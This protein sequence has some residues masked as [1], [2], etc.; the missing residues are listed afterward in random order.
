MP[1]GSCILGVVGDLPCDVVRDRAARLILDAA[2]RAFATLPNA[3]SGLQAGLPQLVRAPAGEPSYWLVP[4]H[5]PSEGVR[6]LARVL[7]D[8]R[9]ATVGVTRTP[10]A[11]A[12]EVATGLSEAA[13]RRSRPGATAGPP[14][15]VH[16]G[17]IGREAWLYVTADEAGAER[18]EFVTGGGTYERPAGESLV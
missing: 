1:A 11:D 8:G 18:W 5:A 15:L 12:A 4:G 17:P 2:Q 10:A 7:L 13:A 14:A 16:D 9:V 3:P 6:A